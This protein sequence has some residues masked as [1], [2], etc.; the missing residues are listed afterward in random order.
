MTLEDLQKISKNLTILYV[1]DEEDIALQVLPY[2]NKFFK[3]IV[4]AKDGEEGFLRFTEKKFDIVLTDIYMPNMNGL[5]MLKKIKEIDPTQNCIIISGYSEISLFIE[6]IKIGVDGYIL[7]PIEFDQMSQSLENIVDKIDKTKAIKEYQKNLENLVSKKTYELK[8]SSKVF[9]NVT[10]G[11]IITNKD[12]MMISVN[13]SFCEIS[14]YADTELIGN[15]PSLLNSGRHETEFYNTM[16]QSIQN[17]STWS[18]KIFNKKK[19]GEIYASFLNISIISNEQ[20]DVENYVGVFT[21]IT[22]VLEYEKD[23]R[24]KDILLSQQSKMAAM[25]EMIDNIAHQWKQPLSI[26]SANIGVLEIKSEFDDFQKEDITIASSSIMN[27]VTY[28]SD[29]IDDFKNFFNT[30]KIKTYFYIKKTVEK[31][32]KLIQSKYKNSD[33][34]VVQNIEEIELY[35]CENELLQVLLNILNNSADAFIKSTIE[36]RLV[37]IDIKKVKN[38]IS[39]IIKDNAG[40]IDK[41]IVDKIFQARFTTKESNNGT[42]IGLYM[43]KKIIQESF[44]GSLIANNE[45]FQYNNIK[46]KGAC[47]KVMIEYKDI[48][49][50]Q[51]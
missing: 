48:D 16:W 5:D 50:D 40:G 30:E 45:L 6:S 22:Q 23:I 17:K 7:Q 34:E 9:E 39:I 11:I 36:K 29:T 33:I 38:K 49:D 2:L 37:F 14:G 15:N 19:N 46:Y 1:E 51:E 41:N 10:E 47:F 43:S 13:K 42:G 25:G 24:A 21:D 31:T 8:I 12:G 28:M 20:N 27:A 32:L 44:G 26:V 3:S 35:A 4:V 18:G